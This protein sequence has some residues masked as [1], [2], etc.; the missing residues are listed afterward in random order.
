VRSLDER[1]IEDLSRNKTISPALEHFMGL[2]RHCE[3]RAGGVGAQHA[4][5]ARDSTTSNLTA[6]TFSTSSAIADNTSVSSHVMPHAN[7]FPRAGA[8]SSP[9]SPTGPMLLDPF[10]SKESF[11]SRKP[12]STA[13]AFRAQTASTSPTR[14]IHSDSIDSATANSPTASR[15][16]PHVTVVVPAQGAVKQRPTSLGRVERTRL[17]RGNE[18]LD[19][20]V[21]GAMHANNNN[22]NSS[23]PNLS[24]HRNS[25]SSNSSICTPSLSSSDTALVQVPPLQMPSNAND[26][27]TSLSAPNSPKSSELKVR[28]TSQTNNS[29]SAS[30]SSPQYASLASTS[31]LNGKPARTMRKHQP[32]DLSEV[33]GDV[34]ANLILSSGVATIETT[35]VRRIETKEREVKEVKVVPLVLEKPRQLQ[36]Q[37]QKAM[38]GLRGAPIL[39]FDEDAELE[40][41]ANP[42]DDAY[43]DEFFLSPRR[44]NSPP[45]MSNNNNSAETRPLSS[46]SPLP[47]SA[48]IATTAASTTTSPAHVPNPSPSNPSP[49]SAGNEKPRKVRRQAAAIDLVAELGGTSARGGLEKAAES[50]VLANELKLV[51]PLDR[52]ALA[53]HNPDSV[54]RGVGANHHRP[55]LLSS[56]LSLHCVAAS[57][58]GVDEPICPEEYEANTTSALPMRFT[59]EWNGIEA[60]WNIGPKMTQEKF[61]RCGFVSRFFFF[62]VLFLV[63]CLFF[64]CLV[65]VSHV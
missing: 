50:H 53:S 5:E 16:S 47:S 60:C 65:L 43:E 14:V 37:N 29:S 62:F 15:S 17:Q 4:T 30:V 27:P 45:L 34:G 56:P 32:I 9:P 54:E 31:N 6:A 55:N 52:Q 2:M 25:S 42:V 35:T 39:D 36:E 33:L 58:G 57:G 20:E 41:E 22:N 8:L 1:T 51:L 7:P 23:L 13:V 12:T 3:P 48:T 26:S 64:F 46:L 11:S 59:C 44:P 28:Y 61:R 63:S 19:R 21:S 24:A 10:S 18:G 38:T 40:M 49:T